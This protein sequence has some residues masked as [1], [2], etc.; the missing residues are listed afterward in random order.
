MPVNNFNVGRDVTLQIVGFDGTIKS[1][2]LYT[3]FTA[4]QD[5]HSVKIIGMDGTVRFMEN[6]AGWSGTMQFDRQ[7]AS[8]DQ[9]FSDL[10]T[11]YY[12][13]TNIQAATITE[14]ISEVSGSITQWRFTGVV[15]K[16]DDAGDWKGDAQVSLKLGWN[17][18]RRIKVQ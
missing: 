18:S 2:A 14:T 8:I 7:D 9:Y 16:L 11:A 6:P 12:G 10:E 4:K 17:A 5:T 3:S 15:F 1:F 13:G